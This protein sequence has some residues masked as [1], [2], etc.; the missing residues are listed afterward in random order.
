MDI[1]NKTLAVFLLAAI[2]V[3]LGGTIVSLNRLDSLSAT[4]FASSGTGN[5]SLNIQ[6]SLSITTADNA[7]INFSS[8]TP[9]SGSEAIINSEGAINTSVVCTGFSTDNIS[10]RN[11]GNVNANVTVRPNV[12]GQAQ[13]GSFLTAASATSAVAYKTIAR[14]IDSY[15]NGCANVSTLVASY[16][17][18]SSTV[19]NVTVCPNLTSGLV[20][21]SVL[22]H[23]QIIVPYDVAAGQQDVILTYVAQNAQ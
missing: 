8:C 3:S 9:L 17:N 7:L 14:G 11:D 22:T 21:N 6:S 18:F 19:T 4:G 16:T 2:V 5:V 15:G 13:G 23:I 12:I 20:N 10:V 1:S